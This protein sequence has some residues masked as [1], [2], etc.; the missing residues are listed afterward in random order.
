M[1][2]YSAAVKKGQGALKKCFKDQPED[3]VEDRAE[4]RVEKVEFPMLPGS[5]TKYAIT[6]GEDA[7]SQDVTVPN[8]AWG[9]LPLLPEKL[10]GFFEAR[11]VKVTKTMETK[12]FHTRLGFVIRKLSGVVGLTVTRMDYQKI[13][14]KKHVKNKRKRDEFEFG[15]FSEEEPGEKQTWSI[16][17]LEKINSRA[18]L[19][20]VAL[21]IE[22][23]VADEGKNMLM[24]SFKHPLRAFQQQS[25]SNDG[26]ITYVEVE[27]TKGTNLP[28]VLG[29]ELVQLAPNTMK[30][31]L[32]FSGEWNDGDALA[33]EGEGKACLK[34]LRWYLDM[35]KK[36]Q[37]TIDKKREVVAG[38][39]QRRDEQKGTRFCDLPGDH[40]ARKA[41]EEFDLDITKETGH[42]D[43]SVLEEEW[44][45]WYD[46]RRQAVSRCSQLFR[47]GC[48]GEEDEAENEEEESD[49]DVDHD[50]GYYQSTRFQLKMLKDMRRT[51]C[52][53]LKHAGLD[54][55]KAE[56]A[57]KGLFLQS[58]DVSEDG[59]L[60]PR[61]VSVRVRIFSSVGQAKLVDIEHEHHARA[62]ASFCE[63]YAH[64][65]AQV[66]AVDPETL[67][68]Q[69][70]DDLAGTVDDITLFD[71]QCHPHTGKR[72]YSLATIK[73][74]QK[75]SEAIFGQRRG[76]LNAFYSFHVFMMAAGADTRPFT[77]M[78]YSEFCPLSYL[79]TKFH[80][81]K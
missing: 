78:D 49:D 39:Q 9:M 3:Y 17:G 22:D 63:E 19:A 45:A 35:L 44:R 48:E 76:P 67:T 31:H 42:W 15:G 37:S 79:E 5:L 62:R 56:A 12:Q 65:K 29:Q 7:G 69:V 6:A 50:E 33:G 18:E 51:Y 1:F 52:N 21:D 38:F 32:Y 16:P 28:A 64:I 10:I 70:V 59:G 2:L 75:L 66:L 58:V 80:H 40:V 47:E 46:L 55:A 57:A 61:T 43:P 24:I 72:T 77:D 4:F 41:V 30:M 74:A 34:E 20:T 36:I 23:V 60:Q 71:M 26:E 54:A 14:G 73:D 11:G 53:A 81:K 13:A 27:E 8:P 68:F 25:I